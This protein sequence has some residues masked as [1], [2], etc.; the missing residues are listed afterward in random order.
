MNQLIKLS[1]TLNDAHQTFFNA[2]IQKQALESSVN[3]SSPGS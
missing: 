3:T 2:F 1:T